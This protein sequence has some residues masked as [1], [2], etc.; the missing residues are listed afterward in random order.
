MSVRWIG[1]VIV[2]LLL[3]SSYPRVLK[4]LYPIPFKPMV[5]ESAREW[6]LDP[7]LLVAV[8]RVESSFNPRAESAKGARGLMQIMPNTGV[9]AARELGIES[10]HPDDLFEPEVNLRIG[11]WYLTYLIRRFDG[12]LPLALA[13]YNGGQGNVRRWLDSMRWNGE[14]DTVKDIPYGETRRFVLRVLRT[15]RA[16]QV[17]YGS[18]ENAEGLRAAPAPR[19][20]AAKDWAPV[21]PLSAGRP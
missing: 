3:V 4:W 8:M 11:A 2:A 10:F 12:R 21:W 14:V 13:A 16:Y 19:R 18:W 15:Y 17:A 9:W 1:L 7:F 5:E 20:G 6:G